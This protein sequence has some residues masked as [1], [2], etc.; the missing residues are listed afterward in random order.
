MRTF[1]LLACFTGLLLAV[2][3]GLEPV[4]VT[5]S[6]GTEQTYLRINT[7][8]GIIEEFPGEPVSPPRFPAD[9]GVLWVDRNHQDAI[10]QSIALSGDGGHVFANWGLNHKRAAYYR[11]LATNRLAR[12]RMAQSLLSPARTSATSGPA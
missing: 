2:P 7:G 9:T 1:I 3:V 4:T 12:P 5:A 10:C 8:T 11:T 6:D